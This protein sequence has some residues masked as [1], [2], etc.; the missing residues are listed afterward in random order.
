MQK[1]SVV[2]MIPI[3][4]SRTYENEMRIDL[5]NNERAQAIEE[6]VALLK[7]GS[8]TE[9]TDEEAVLIEQI[10]LYLSEMEA[11][12]AELGA[13]TN[14][15]EKAKNV[16]KNSMLWLFIYIFDFDFYTFIFIYI[17]LNYYS[18]GVIWGGFEIWER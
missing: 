5:L 17:F 3:D 8:P 16:T 9:E 4:D 7:R 15:L 14:K 11:K 12:F 10:T 1:L 13:K 18:C 2:A 6:S